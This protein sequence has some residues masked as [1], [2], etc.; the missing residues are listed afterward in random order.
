M[1][2]LKVLGALPILNGAWENKNNLWCK[3]NGLF[4]SISV[5]F[6]YFLV[7]EIYIQR[8]KYS[9]ISNWIDTLV[10]S[11]YGVGVVSHQRIFL[12]LVHKNLREPFSFSANT[13]GAAHS[14][15]AGSTT[16]IFYTLLIS[17]VLN[18]R[19]TGLAQTRALCTRICRA[20]ASY[21]QWFGMQV[22]HNWPSR[23]VSNSS[24]ILKNL[25]QYP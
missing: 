15:L 8:R 19:A 23:F 22:C 17:V 21:I 18:S 11:T 12:Q 16:S 4:S 2:R 13:V 10:H 1:V 5:L 7:E 20:E 6:P 9:C 14:D 24:I 25:S 3:A